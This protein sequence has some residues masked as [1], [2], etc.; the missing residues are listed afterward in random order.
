MEGE[1]DLNAF[2]ALLRK[3]DVMPVSVCFFISTLIHAIETE[4]DSGDC[5]LSVYE[6]HRSSAQHNSDL[7]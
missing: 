4:I 2:F 7:S 5:R 1:V 6:G 3:L